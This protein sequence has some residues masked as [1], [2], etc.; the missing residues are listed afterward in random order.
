VSLRL[1]GYLSQTYN[2]KRTKQHQHQS[3]AVKE[4]HQYTF[5]KNNSSTP[6]AR[7]KQHSNTSNYKENMD[8]QARV[9]T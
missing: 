2:T 7:N 9:Y 4:Q 5:T 6:A 1:H 3:A 8:S